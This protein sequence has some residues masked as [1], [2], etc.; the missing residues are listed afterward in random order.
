VQADVAHK[1]AQRTA[2][3]V[4][5]QRQARIRLVRRL[6]VGAILL[7]ATGAVILGGVYAGSS[8]TLSDGESIA[9]VDV[10]GL[11]TKQAVRL[12]ERRAAALGNAPVAVRVAGHTFRLRQGEIGVRVDWAGAVSSARSQADG[13]GPIRGFRRLLLL[14]FGGTVTP[15]ARADGRAL[16]LALDKILR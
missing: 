16:D 11:T 7:L 5:R 2:L 12:L 9:G 8:N 1:E 3:R 14:A 4:R 13:F 6:V 10:G 15:A